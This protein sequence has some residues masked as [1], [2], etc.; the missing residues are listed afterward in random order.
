MKTGTSLR[1]MR[2]PVSG[3]VMMRTPV[4][5]RL[6]MRTP[7]VKPFHYYNTHTGSESKVDLS[8]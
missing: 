8:K 2:T 3:W 7:V 5:G 6:M 1:L 4:S